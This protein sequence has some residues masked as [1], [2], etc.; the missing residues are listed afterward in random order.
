MASSDAIQV[1]SFPL[2]PV[3]YINL[4]TDENVRQNSAPRPP[5]PIHDT[6]S[7]FGNICNVDDPIIR[8]L[9]AQGIKMLSSRHFDWRRELKK[10]NRSLLVNFLDLID[11]LVLCPES[12]KRAEKVIISTNLLVITILFS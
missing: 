8:P 9:E 11:V 4:Y 12:P 5:P 3:Q 2:P 6:Y 1:T 7:L 10:L